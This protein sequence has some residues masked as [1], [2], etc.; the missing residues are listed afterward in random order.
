MGDLFYIRASITLSQI[1][2][3]REI[4]NQT[5]LTVCSLVFLL[6]KKETINRVGIRLV[7]SYLE[8][9]PPGN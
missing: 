7:V 6:K 4:L 5:V 9:P 2:K 1:L 8:L 3:Q